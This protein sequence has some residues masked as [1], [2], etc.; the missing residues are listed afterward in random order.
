MAYDPEGASGDLIVGE[1]VVDGTGL[2]SRNGE[3]LPSRLEGRAE[4]VNHRAGWDWL[5][6]GVRAGG[7]CGV[8]R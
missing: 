4:R 2:V 7:C 3:V 5:R 1:R 8:D 6:G